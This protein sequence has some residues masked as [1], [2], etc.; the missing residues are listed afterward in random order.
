M[1][2][3]LHEMHEIGRRVC[4]LDGTLCVRSNADQMGAN[5]YHLSHPCR[6][7]VILL[8]IGDMGDIV[9][10][11]TTDGAFMDYEV[12]GNKVGFRFG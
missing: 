12:V 6:E 10:G 8:C 2:D 7:P 3:P 9:V 1:D 4:E 5:G 11:T